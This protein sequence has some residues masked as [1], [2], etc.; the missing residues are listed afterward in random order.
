VLSPE[1]NYTL[2]D[3]RSRREFKSML[4]PR[5][6]HF[7]ARRIPNKTDLNN[8]AIAIRDQTAIW[9]RDA[10]DNVKFFG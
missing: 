7:Y 4:F 10:S 9:P 3:R 2:R 1:V 8:E 5:K 6:F